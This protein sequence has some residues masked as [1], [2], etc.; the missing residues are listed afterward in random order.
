PADRRKEGTGFDLAIAIGVLLAS[1]QLDAA[2][3]TLL[4]AELALDGSLRPVR[5]CLPRVAAAAA[6]GV[7]EVIVSPENAA[8]GSAVDGVAVIAAAT[9]RD[10]AAHLDRTAPITPRIAEAMPDEPP[11]PDVDFADVAGSESARRALEIPAAG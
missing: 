2:G 9:L 4:I 10:V 8:E 7:R 6:R 11:R 1:N 5:G 3:E